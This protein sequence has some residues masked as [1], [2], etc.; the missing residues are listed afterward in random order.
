MSI[1]TGE[2]YYKYMEEFNIQELMRAQIENDYFTPLLN[3]LKTRK[4]EKKFGVQSGVKPCMP[5]I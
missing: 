3:F 2:E 5:T 4:S 1:Q